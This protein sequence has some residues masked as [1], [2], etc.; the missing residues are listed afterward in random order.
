[1]LLSI[2]LFA[3]VIGIYLAMQVEAIGML[4]NNPILTYMLEFSSHLLI[5]VPALLFVKNVAK[6]A[7]RRLLDICM[8]GTLISVVVQ[9]VLQLATPLEFRQMLIVA[10]V[11]MVI[12]ILA[13]I[14]V[15]FIRLGIIEGYRRELTFSLI[16]VGVF[17]I[18]EMVFHYISTYSSSGVF[19]KAGVMVFIVMQLRA[20]VFI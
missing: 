13:S 19:F 3:V 14:Y 7:H 6:E 15:M 18:L 1:M 11:V 10:Q 16:P 17:G 2:G 8:V 5:T 9:C 4:I 20:L 12:D